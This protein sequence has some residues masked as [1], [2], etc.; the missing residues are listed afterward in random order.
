MSRKNKPNLVLDLDETLIHS[1]VKKNFDE[2]MNQTKMNVFNY[3]YM[4]DDYIVF[5]RPYLQE[6]L[7]YAFENFDV[8]IWTAAS[9]DY[10]LFIL[11]NFILTKP[12]RKLKYILYS[13]HCDLSY[14]NKDAS[15]DLSMF[16]EVWKS[17]G[18]DEK[19]TYILDDNIEVFNTQKSKCIRAKPF[20]F[21]N[22]SSIKD[23]FLKNVIK[24]LNKKL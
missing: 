17:N 8:S 7:D 23:N 4:D 6:F 3:K 18:F 12:N 10:M 14:D 1:V 15:K 24:E 19:N 9:K 2:K 11:K 21:T 16:W 22:K 13:Y 5:E 20:K